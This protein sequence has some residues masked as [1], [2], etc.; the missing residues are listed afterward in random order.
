[1]PAPARHRARDLGLDIGL[2]PTGPMNAI[3][4]VPGVLVGHSTIWRDEPDPPAGRGVARTGITAILPGAPLELLRSPVPC[5]VAVLNGAGELTAAAQVREW[6]LLETP[7][8]L[9]STMQVGRAYDAVVELLCDL[10]PSVGVERVVIPMVGECDDSWL[11]DARRAQIT[12]DDV[13]AAVAGAGTDVE[14]GAVGAGT[15]MVC[16]DF[17]GGIGTASRLA[18]GSGVTVGV[19]LQTNFGSR[20]RLTI[21]GVPVGRLLGPSLEQSVTPGGSCIGVVATDAPCTPHQLE[22]LARRV[23]LGLARCGSVAHH[24]SGEIFTA[25]STVPPG[26]GEP[27][28]DEHLD[29]LFAGVVEAAEEA[30]V[31][32]L[33][34]ATTVTGARGHMV[35]ALP[36]DE[37]LELLRA[38]GRVG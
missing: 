25:F 16:F 11:N 32:S 31:N 38:A 3:T 19:L 7:I 21:D 30:V 35:E 17:K 37:T 10:D 6:G 2:L 14:E 27:L 26:D 8:A 12:V 22:R 15:G 20:E 5:G 13:R 36:L 29:E 28:P 23:G 34:S 24:G 33:T 18:I 1:M 9:T 4:D